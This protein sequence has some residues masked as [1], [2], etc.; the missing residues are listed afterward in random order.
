MTIG[1][2]Q[3][4]GGQNLFA[5]INCINISKRLVALCSGDALNEVC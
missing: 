4:N 1:L 3:Q 2:P 5:R